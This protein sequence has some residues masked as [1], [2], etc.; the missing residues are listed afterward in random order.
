ME[1][2]C[3]QESILILLQQVFSIGNIN[4]CVGENII[5]WKHNLNMFLPHGSLFYQA[6]IKLYHLEVYM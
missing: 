5:T 6:R 4:Y 1:K 3:S 2:D